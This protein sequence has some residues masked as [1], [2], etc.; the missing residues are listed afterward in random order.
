M[1]L[2]IFITASKIDTDTL[3]GIKEIIPMESHYRN[4]GHSRFG[5]GIRGRYRCHVRPN[6][7]L[8]SFVKSRGCLRNIDEQ[9][10]NSRN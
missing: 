9:N 10:S 5:I 7:I 1:N 2:I 4:N 6:I 3:S 8:I